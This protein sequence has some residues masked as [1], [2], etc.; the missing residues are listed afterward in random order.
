MLLWLDTLIGLVVILLAASLI[1][2]ILTQFVVMLLSL[3]GYN[4]RNSISI[5]LENLDPTLKG[6]AKEISEQVLSHP[7][8]S[9][10]WMRFHWDIIKRWGLATSIRKEELKDILEKLVQDGDNNLINLSEESFKTL[11]KEIDTWFDKSMNRASQDFIR[12][13]RF[14][15]IIFSFIIAFSFHLDI[16]SIFEQISTDPELRAKI[17]VT[18][19]AW[20][21]KAEDFIGRSTSVPAKAIG[22]LKMQDT[23]GISEKL[24]TPPYFSNSEEGEKWIRTQVM[25]TDSSDY[26]I[27]LYRNMVDTVIVNSKN[28]ITNFAREINKDFNQI[29]LKLGRQSGEGILKYAKLDRHFFG[30]LI[31]AAFLSLGAPFWFK[32]LKTLSGLRPILANKVDEEKKE[33]KK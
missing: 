14:W 16:I 26:L 15:T 10:K 2:M 5:L 20:V 7:L 19:E 1:V 24:G 11:K 28:E 22:M 21:H 27:G 9:D 31:M 33:S 3:R 30:V 6:K 4:L 12:Q 29:G 25:G 13:T 23:T 32:A 17:V 8:I 18:H